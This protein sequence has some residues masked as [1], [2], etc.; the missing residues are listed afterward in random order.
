MI[1]SLSV[2]PSISLTQRAATPSEGPCSL[3]RARRTRANC[4]ARVAM[5]GAGFTIR[6]RGH[7]RSDTPA[8]SR[9]G[10]NPP[11]GV[12]GDDGDVCIIR[13]PL[14]RHRPTRPGRER[15]RRCFFRATPEIAATREE[16]HGTPDRPTTPPTRSRRRFQNTLIW[17]PQYV[18]ME[19]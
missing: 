16:A 11:Y 19:A 12:K 17:I 5:P 13:S 15:N 6:R 1:H 4:A 2:K 18:T 14:Q 7:A 9:T 10:E 8:L 3:R